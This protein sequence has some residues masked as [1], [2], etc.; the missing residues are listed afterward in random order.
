MNKSIFYVMVFHRFLNLLT[1]ELDK[2][3]I[4]HLQATIKI[5]NLNKMTR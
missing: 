2:D 4:R 3:E 1:L 5:N